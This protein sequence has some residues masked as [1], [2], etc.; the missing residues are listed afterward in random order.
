M[1]VTENT[2][3]LTEMPK[4]RKK[5]AKKG[6][7][8]DP[9]LQQE[10]PVE[11]YRKTRKLTKYGLPRCPN[12]Q[13]R[14]PTTKECVPKHN[15]TRKSTSPKEE[16]ETPKQEDEESPKEEEPTEESKEQPVEEEQKEETKKDIEEPPKEEEPEKD[17]NET[18]IENPNPGGLEQKV[19]NEE[20]VLESKSQESSKPS[21]LAS[22]LPASISKSLGISTSEESPKES[23]NSESKSESE[24]QE[25]SEEQE[26][27]EIQEED[28]EFVMDNNQETFR[29][30]INEYNY[31]KENVTEKNYLYPNMND[32]NFSEKIL[33]KQEFQ[34]NKF[35][36]TINKNI[37]EEADKQCDT[38]FEIMPHQQFV[39]NFMSS[40]TPYNSL[41]LY[42]D[43]G[44][45]KTCSAIGITEEM[46]QYMKQS[47]IDQK[48]I[49]IASPN[50]QEN[51]QL[52]LFDP[53]KLK[54]RNG[55]WSLNTCA[56]NN[57]LNEINPTFVE[58]IPRKK[59]ISMVN[60]LI[61]KYYSFMG[62]EQVA[63]YSES[64]QKKQEYRDRRKSK[65]KRTLDTRIDENIPE[66]INMEPLS[67][68]D[69]PE[70]RKMKLKLIKR[71]RNMFDNRLIVIDEVHNMLAHSKD[72]KKRSSKILSKIVR[73]C[74]NTRFV[75]LSATP[76]YNS[77]TE[78]TWLVN[79]MNLNDNRS[80][81][82]QSQLFDSNGDF[83]QEKVSSDNVIV[84]ESGQDL[85]RRKLIG[86]VSYVRGENPYSFPYRIYPKDFA[87]PEHVLGTY[88][89]PTKQMNGS[90]I[91]DAPEKYVLDNVFVTKIGSYQNHA[92]L[93]VIAKLMQNEQFAK[94]GV[95]MDE[96][97]KKTKRGFGFQELI[98]PLSI[99]NM[100][101][102]YEALEEH[103]ETNPN[104]HYK[105]Q[106]Q[107][108]HGTEGLF[109]T[110]DYEHENIPQGNANMK[111]YSNFSYKPSILEKH[112]R[113]FQKDKLQK[114]SGKIHSIVSSIEKS[115]GI[116][117][118]Y[119]KYIEG[120]LLPMALALEEMGFMRYSYASHIKSFMKEKQPPLDPLTMKP[121]TEKSKSY[122]KYVMITGTRS[123]S[124]D[125]AKDLEMVF[126]PDNKEGELVKVV[127]ISQAGS[128]GI[129]FKC[130]RQVHIM[131]PWYNMSRMEQ[132][133]GRAVRNK[134]HCALP[135]EKRNVEIYMHATLCENDNES[136]DM[137]LYRLAE[138]K[139]IQIGHITRI[140]KETAVDCMLNL[141][142]NNFTEE[143]MDATIK[144]TLS[145]NQKE[146][147]YKVGDKPFSSKCDFMETC[148]Y[149]CNGTKKQ[150]KT[151]EHT[152]AITHLSRS[153]DQISKRIRQLF[154][155]QTAYKKESL[156]QSIQVGKPYNIQD[157]YYTLG[158]FLKNKERLTHKGKTGYLIKKGDYYSFQPIEITNIHSSIYERM[159]PI[160]HKPS[161]ATVILPEE[162]EVPIV[163][164]DPNLIEIV[165]KKEPTLAEKKEDEPQP[166]ISVQY[167][168][169]D[170][171]RIESTIQENI[172]SITNNIPYVHKTTNKYTD[173]AKMGYQILTKRH[174][175]KEEEVVYYFILHYIE[176][177]SFHDK[178]TCIKTLFQ[179]K[180][181]FERNVVKT[182]TSLNDVIYSYFRNEMVEHDD[183]IGI[184]IGND[185][186]N[187]LLLWKS[188]KWEDGKDFIVDVEKLMPKVNEKYNKLDEILSKVRKE[189]KK[190]NVNQSMVGYISHIPKEG[191]YEFKTKDLLQGRNSKGARCIQEPKPTNIKRINE[192]LG[193]LDKPNTEYYSDE[194][195]FEGF[196]IY[197][198]VLCVVFEVLLRHHTNSS[199]ETW[200]L[201]YQESLYIHPSLLVYDKEKSDWSDA[202]KKKLKK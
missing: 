23:D 22:I 169:N 92:Y 4:E 39:R 57:L 25:K 26:E 20:L 201:N 17:D 179:E 1:E 124:P 32:P 31:L 156:R 146:I 137:Y 107:P 202:T 13:V 168:E 14:D 65:A 111:I 129:D 54:E 178:M 56:G 24:E 170:Y 165:S 79:M 104:E 175:L 197:K 61:N 196:N 76:V 70:T 3:P 157:I 21:F 171:G 153:Y 49:V 191:I 139:A 102:P 158:V 100:T 90:D 164:D 81:I 136:A 12:G 180:K 117:L 73:Y 42:H 60:H 48:I 2:P 122:A 128:E 192:L 78:I 187:Q 37:E 147:D 109:N 185:S 40:Q 142:Q 46:R 93:A 150:L 7:R 89:Y 120:G 67:N 105:K 172:D 103:I 189:L 11:Q 30:E 112:G 75:F 132:I 59:V 66:I 138:K 160:D 86:Y 182:Y 152:Y 98:T 69:D 140:L 184:Y 87:E 106:L 64:D 115:S 82:K 77:H 123:F 186:E 84:Q 34:N 198:Q 154:Q 44:T 35:N 131:D 188:G 126:H 58:G 108:L 97:A 174:D 183:I 155:D 94:K 50:V 118:I 163:P 41:L 43:L 161:H 68:D 85:L 127:M 36:G 151:D 101:Y 199:G 177:L 10:V 133:I 18:K 55:L 19:N 91:E 148:E 144:L 176:C 134:S 141:E 16:E 110:M 51:F 33:S 125:N 63:L 80:T 162:N 52:Q 74:E 113:I 71:L 149:K 193:Y 38:P 47:G 72:D 145:S 96:N 53:S 45:G 181:D 200:F 194:T 62:Y 6:Y 9:K 15:I 116:V 95:V 190:Q 173:F 143:N 83:V 166:R 195:Q 29:D 167:N 130:I 119:S 27:Q 99:L 5:R 135:F 88:S 121:K 159:A 28:E 114:F 8:W